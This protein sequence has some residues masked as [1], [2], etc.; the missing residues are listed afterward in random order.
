MTDADL[1][2][3]ALAPVSE[4]LFLPLYAVA[5]E[6]AR[7]DDAILQDPASEALARRLD[8]VFADSTLGLHRK[9][10]ARRLPGLMVT[11]VCLRIRHFDQVVRAFR[12]EHPDGLVVTLGCGLSGRV[13]RVDGGTGPWVELDLP[14]VMRLREGL[15]PRREN[16]RRVPGDALN[17]GWMDDLPEADG[18]PVLFLAEGL[19][20]YLPEGA[21]RRLVTTLAARFPGATLVAE[22]SNR[23]VVEMGQSRMGRGK[24]RRQFGLSA[25][26]FFRSG[27]SRPDEMADWGGG[28]TFESAWRY[29]DEDEPRLRMWRV[30]AGWELF[31][32][33]Q[34]VVRVR[35]G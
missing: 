16:V 25:D 34:Y 9:L 21:V 35:F 18:R 15:I 5:T 14:L 17:P 7:G 8:A 23:R 31:G 24:L 6:S 26:V 3:L 32:W 11:T 12:A 33:A 1:A 10:R 30:F 20:M 13:G 22:V 27:L 4:T 28:I 2:T 19:F 29:W